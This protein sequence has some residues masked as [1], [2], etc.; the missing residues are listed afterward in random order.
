MNCGKIVLEIV[1]VGDGS[2]VIITKTVMIKWNS[3]IKNHYVDLG[4]KFTKMGDEVEVNVKDLTSG[5]NL[6]VQNKCDGCGDIYTIVYAEYNRK[7]HGELYYC[8]KCGNDLVR[9]H[10]L[11]EESRK[12]LS[13][14][15]KGVKRP[16]MLG[17]NNPA[18]R[19]EVREKLAGVNNPM[20]G[21]ARY[22]IRGSKH[23][24]YNPNLTDYERTHK[25]QELQGKNKD[26][27]SRRVFIKDNYTCKCCCKRG[28]INLVAHHLNSWNW[29][30][31]NRH[32]LDNGITLCSA[33]HKAFHKAYG[34]GNNTKEQYIEFSKS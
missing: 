32:E 27:W 19:P 28:G 18:K 31:E 24:R 17:E 30:I 3:K 20:Y 23:P 6:L 29:D 16:D 21:V 11:S 15:K 34:Y 25:R 8:V 2:S 14:S 22:E 5:S 1:K 33:C 4:Y 10:T 26:T 13:M 7:K 9:S 12:K